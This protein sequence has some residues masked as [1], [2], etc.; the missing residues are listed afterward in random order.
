MTKKPSTR[1]SIDV[2]DVKIE[3][4]KVTI[5]VT[6]K[7]PKKDEGQDAVLTHPIVQVKFNKKASI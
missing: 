2:K 4:D 3:G 6:E 7:S 1:Y 5:Y